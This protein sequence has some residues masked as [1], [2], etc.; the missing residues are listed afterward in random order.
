MS[1]SLAQLLK[2][3]TQQ[4]VETKKHNGNVPWIT[5]TVVVNT[6]LL[7]SSVNIRTIKKECSTSDQ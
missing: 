1:D 7:T 2:T 5:T 4:Q 6:G 3:H